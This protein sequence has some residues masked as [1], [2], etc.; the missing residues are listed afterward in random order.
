MNIEEALRAADRRR[1]R[2]MVGA[3]TDALAKL[4]ADELIWTHSSGKTDGKRSF[5]EKIASGSVVY[6]SLDVA[7]D[8]VS[9]HGDVAIHHGTLSG[10]VSVDG[11]ERALRN[12]FL[13]VWKHSGDAFQLL[14]WQSTGL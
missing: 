2:A 13:A 10:R 5:L 6:L 14:A 9:S 12:R 8:A 1:R 3:D 11:R 7:N 4:L